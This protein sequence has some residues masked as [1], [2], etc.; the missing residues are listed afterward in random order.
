M[1]SDHIKKLFMEQL[2]R[3]P[4]VEIACEKV[5]LSRATYYR[6]H[7]DN[8]DFR[9]QSDEA[10]ERGFEY[11]NDLS[12]SQVLTLIKEKKMPAITLW[13]KTHHPRYGSKAKM[14][15]PSSSVRHLNPEDPRYKKAHKVALRYEQE[16]RETIIKDIHGKNT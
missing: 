7:K 4:I 10:L 16:L 11:V 13:L 9:K 8:L 6:W 2:Q 5:G 3:V 14:Q 15:T 1:K 12:E